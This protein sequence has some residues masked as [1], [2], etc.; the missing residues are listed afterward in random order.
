MTEPFSIG[1]TVRL[2]SGSP[3]MTVT[4]V[5]TDEDNTAWISCMWFDGKNKQESSFPA[6]ALKPI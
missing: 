3:T 4:A 5:N 2:K 6:N 1:D